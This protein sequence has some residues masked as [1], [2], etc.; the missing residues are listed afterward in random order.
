MTT[1]RKE[2]PETT[3]TK[4]IRALLDLMKVPHLKHFGGPLAQRG[5]SDLICTLPPTGRGCYIE[6]K[7]PGRKP[8]P[9]QEAFLYSMAQA[10]ALA[11]WVT[12]PQ[13]MLKK[14]A[15]AGFEPARRITMQFPQ[16]L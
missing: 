6:V 3:L 14:L 7:V 9:E 4:Q 1:E 13:E 12:S 5:V 11:F 16:G 8:N 10:G 2:N 15:E